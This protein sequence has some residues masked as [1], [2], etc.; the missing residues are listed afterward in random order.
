MEPVVDTHTTLDGGLDYRFITNIV[1]SNGLLDP[2][3]AF[4]LVERSEA[5]DESIVV[6]LIPDGGH[7]GGG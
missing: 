1:F 7:H 2:W 6:I 5:L 4:G 3:S